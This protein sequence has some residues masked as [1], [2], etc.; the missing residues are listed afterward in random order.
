MKILFLT[1]YYEPDIAANA[2]IMTRL[3]EEL[4]RRGHQITVVTSFPHY[5]KN[6]VEEDFRGKF[7]QREK[8]EGIHIIRCFLYT[9]KKKEKMW[10]RLLNYVSFNVLST[11]A[12][13]FSGPYDLI[14]APSPPLSIGF[15]A[16]VLGVLKRVPFIY[17]VQDINPDVL[18]KLGILKNDLAI[19]FSKWLES[20]VYRKAKHLTVISE[21]FKQNLL[22]KGVPEKKISVIPNFVD[23]DFMKPGAGDGFRKEYHLEE[24]FLIMYAG[25]LGHSKDL[26]QVLACAKLLK[27]EKHFHFVIVGDGSRK[28]NLLCRAN[29]M[30]LDNVTFLPFQPRDSVPELYS[31]SDISLVSLKMGLA[32]DSLPSKVYSIM[33]C[34]RP[35]LAAVDEGS[36]VWQLVKETGSGV[37]VPPGSPRKMAQAIHRLYQDPSRRKEMGKSGRDYV[38]EYHTRDKIGESYHQ[39]IDDLF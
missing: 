19:R 16:Y 4:A 14:F 7:F 18:I 5:E 11:L 31:A 12:G 21:G 10:V 38:L 8:K 17:N 25:N 39:L 29:A 33:A 3:A 26:E 36:D 28:P 9:S 1:L 32:G 6:I 2:V 37:C 13:L 24:D 22:R 30:D 34:E 27:E 15:T 35:V 23:A 20:F